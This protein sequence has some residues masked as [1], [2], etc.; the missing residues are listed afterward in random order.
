MRGLASAFGLEFVAEIPHKS[1]I[2]VEWQFGRFRSSQFELGLEEVEQ[3]NV[4]DFAMAVL[5]ENQTPVGARVRK[6]K[7]PRSNRFTHERESHAF[8]GNRR[9]QPESRTTPVK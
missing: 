6:P 2:E 7:T 8:F 3:G 9:V 1:A 5:I 4:E